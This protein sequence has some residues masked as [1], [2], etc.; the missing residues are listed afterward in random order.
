MLISILAADNKDGS[1]ATVQ[2]QLV[3]PC[4]YKCTSWTKFL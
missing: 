1:I 2:I 3:M 4:F